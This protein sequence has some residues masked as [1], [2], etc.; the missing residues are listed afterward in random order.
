MHFMT[1]TPKRISARSSSS[2]QTPS[3]AIN[4]VRRMWALSPAD[5][6]RCR[7]IPQHYVVT[8]DSRTLQLNER[9][10]RVQPVA[11]S[12]MEVKK[13]PRDKVPFAPSWQRC[14]SADAGGPSTLSCGGYGYNRDHLST[15]K[16]GWPSEYGDP[17]QKIKPNDRQPPRAGVRCCHE[18]AIKKRSCSSR[19]N[20]ARDA[21]WRAAS[22][23]LI[24]GTRTGRCPPGMGG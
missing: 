24:I 16:M 19:N 20:Y 22:T 13:R 11:R 10:G 2:P 17:R 12:V 23:M 8:K 7:S 6:M 3:P 5:L 18:K 9:T 15:A 14:A 4:C 21:W 1:D